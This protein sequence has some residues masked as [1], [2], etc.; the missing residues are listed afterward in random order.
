MRKRSF[1]VSEPKHTRCRK[2]L[3]STCCCFNIESSGIGCS[4]GTIVVHFCLKLFDLPPGTAL[5]SGAFGSWLRHTTS[6]QTFLFNLP[7]WLFL[8]QGYFKRKPKT[9]RLVVPPSRGSG[10]RAPTG[11][12]PCESAGIVA[13]RVI[14][15]LPR[16]TSQPPA[17][18]Q[19][20]H[21]GPFPSAGSPQRH[22]RLIGSSLWFVGMRCF[23]M[24]RQLTQGD[25]VPQVSQGRFYICMHSPTPLPSLVAF[26]FQR[27]QAREATR[28]SVRAG[29]Q[30]IC[31]A[32]LCQ[33]PSLGN[34][35]G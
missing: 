31:A 24:P 1:P 12:V 33:G 17:A 5:S 23:A 9:I 19:Q 29:P 4:S 34:T 25:G 8:T 18:G 16:W 7:S 35:P 15:G 32:V 22:A 11:L 2:E 26:F 10:G 14:P 6:S 3:Y 13:W 21:G 30:T 28:G 27:G 20:K